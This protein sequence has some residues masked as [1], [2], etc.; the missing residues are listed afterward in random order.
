MSQGILGIASIQSCSPGERMDETLL[1]E[2][3]SSPN[4]ERRDPF[5]NSVWSIDRQDRRGLFGL[6]VCLQSEYLFIKSVGLSS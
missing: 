1:R 6:S 4:D 2:T 5:I 3:K